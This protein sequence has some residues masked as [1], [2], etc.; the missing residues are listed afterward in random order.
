MTCSENQYRVK[1]LKL[2]KTPVI[3]ALSFKTLPGCESSKGHRVGTQTC[4]GHAEDEGLHTWVWVALH[5]RVTATPR[6]FSFYSIYCTMYL[7]VILMLPFVLFC[8]LKFQKSCTDT[9]QCCL[10]LDY[11]CSAC[12]DIYKYSLP[13][14]SGHCSF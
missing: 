12:V 2:Y 9:T 14:H 4:D 11:I 10:L 8:C 5:P 7:I 1:G 13:K 3:L 6:R